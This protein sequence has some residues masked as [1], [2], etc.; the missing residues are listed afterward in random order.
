M[1]LPPTHPLMIHSDKNTI[2]NN[3]IRTSSYIKSIRLQLNGSQ[4][5]YQMNMKF[6][7]RQLLRFH[8]NCG[9]V[10]S[11][12]HEHWMPFLWKWNFRRYFLNTSMSCG[13]LCN[14]KFFL[15]NEI[16]LGIH[17]TEFVR[18]KR[19]FKD[20]KICVALRCLFTKSANIVVFLCLYDSVRVKE[21]LRIYQ[22][23][24]PP[25]VPSLVLG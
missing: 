25:Y 6:I 5:K 10:A 4:Y 14:G 23:R 15:E 20:Q 8:S 9:P 2:H 3:A 16:M 11:Q 13:G 19:R 24:R 18:F 7:R 1:L 17:R 12:C 21:F 22:M